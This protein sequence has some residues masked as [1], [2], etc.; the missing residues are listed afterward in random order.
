MDYSTWG[1]PFGLQHKALDAGAGSGSSTVDSQAIGVPKHSESDGEV[2]KGIQ[3]RG[4]GYFERYGIILIWIVVT[5]IFSVLRP[6]SFATLTNFRTILGTQAV[7]LILTLGLLIPL[8]VGEYD[9][10]VAAVMDV[11]AVLVAELSGVHHVNILLAALATLLFGLLIG[12]VNSFVVV[13]LGVSSF[14][15]T[16]GIGTLLGGVSYGISG[17]ATVG[18]ISSRLLTFAA[19]DIFGLPMAFYYGVIICVVVWYIFEHTP[20]GRHLV[21]VG[22]G[23][24]VARLSGLPVSKIRTG[25]LVVSA[26]TASFVGLLQAGVVGAA[27]PG[28]GSSF[29]LPAFAAAFLG[30]TVV[31][32]GRFNAWGSFVAVYFLVTGITGLELLGYTGWVQDVFYGGALVIAVS[33]GRIAASSKKSTRKGAFGSKSTR[34]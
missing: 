25:A 13:R 19:H 18:N 15:T 30:A 10:S 34:R 24:E 22:E 28:S 20:L 3:N 1:T 2:D 31:K 9:L 5:V 27:E 33:L 21:F 23:R 4:P 14:I 12:L 16:L 7:L 26:V 6:Q 17:S 32:P 8:T 11:S 29:L